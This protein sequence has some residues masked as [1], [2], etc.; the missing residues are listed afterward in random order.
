[1]GSKLVEI[2][3]TSTLPPVLRHASAVGVGVAR[4][5]V[6]VLVGVSVGGSG[7]GLGVTVSVGLI[8]TLI[9]ACVIVGAAS[10]AEITSKEIA[11]VLIGKQ[12]DK[13]SVAII[14]IA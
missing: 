12:A 1:L 10:L 6:F 7:L 2:S 9:I 13:S 8:E 3:D 11:G 4:I 14:K 5:G